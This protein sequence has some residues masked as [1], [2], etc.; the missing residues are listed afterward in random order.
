MGKT[1]KWYEANMSHFELWSKKSGIPWRAIKPH[2]ESTIE[3][4]R[5]LWPN[6]LKDLPMDVEHKEQFI[7]LKDAQHQG[8]PDEMSIM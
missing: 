2:L 7:D 6:A 4:A 5:V 8:L 1:K 3:K